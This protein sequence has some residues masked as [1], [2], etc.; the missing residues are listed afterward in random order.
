MNKA[1]LKAELDKRAIAYDEDATNPVLE[2]LL[3]PA[4]E[5]EAEALAK[6]KEA[7]AK[8]ADEAEAKAKAEADA[9]AAE[10]AAK[11]SKVATKQTKA[12]YD[13]VDIIG[14]RDDGR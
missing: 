14:L 6:A 4:L 10:E 7:E 8:I 3:K 2:G 11:A 12:K 13:K 5:A 1:E 9:T